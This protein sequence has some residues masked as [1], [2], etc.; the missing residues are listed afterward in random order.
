MGCL[1]KILKKLLLIAAIIA[2]F[3]FGGY[4]FVKDKIKAYQYPPR[5]IF[6]ESQKEL[7][8]FSNVSG[9]YQLYRSFNFFG[10]KK[11][12]AKYLPTG[13]KITIFD[14]NDEDLITVGD[15]KT[16]EI[17][18]KIN[19]ILSKLKDSLVTYQ[20]FEIIEH[21]T[22]YAKNKEIP[23]IKYKANVKNVPFKDVIGII[24][25]FSNQ[26]KNQEYSTKLIISIVD[27]KAFNPK[28]VSDFVKSLRF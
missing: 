23:Y 25:A 7:A 14:L 4:T 12:G 6:V 15:F 20:N 1:I 8:D 2:F 19:Q 9:D 10:Y 21:G 27:T 22:Y 24:G 11:V 28:I 18:N 5:D 13:Q 16:N 17:D 26:N 3:A